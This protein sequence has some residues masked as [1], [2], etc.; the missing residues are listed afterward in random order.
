LG[1][2]ARLATADHVFLHAL[3]REGA[4]KSRRMK[5]GG[6]SRIYYSVT[7]KCLKRYQTLASDWTTL[8]EAIQ[9]VIAGGGRGT[10]AP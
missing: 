5:V 7:A 1:A 10:A 6:R 9:S 8:A 2:A 3:E 4:L